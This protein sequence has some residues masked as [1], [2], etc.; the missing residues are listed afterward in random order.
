MRRCA[1]LQLP[2]LVVSSFD[3]LRFAEMREQGFFFTRHVSF[4]FQG[5]NDFITRVD[6]MVVHHLYAENPLSLCI[7]QRFLYYD[8]ETADDTLR[9]HTVRLELAAHS[10]PP[11]H[12]SI[13]AT[14]Y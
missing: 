4:C 6:M 10:N 7:G 11:Q 1:A 13:P 3:P 8:C 14:G 2:I 12:R 9:E 5:D